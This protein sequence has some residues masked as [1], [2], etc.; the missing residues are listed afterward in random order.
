MKQVCILLFVLVAGVNLTA[1]TT[2]PPVVSVS[3]GRLRGRLSPPPGGAFFL[4]VPFAEPPVGDL[5]WR[6]PVP[7]KPWTGVREASEFGSPC[8]QIDAGWNHDTA[9]R[10]AEDCLYL[11]IWTPEWPEKSPQP[12]MVWLHGGAN[13]GG[14]ASFGYYG[15]VLA[16]KGVVIVTVNYR[17]GVLGFLA[18]PELTAES[19]HHSSGNYGLLDQIAALRWV[20]ENIAKFG[21]DP[22][23]VTIFG[24]SAGGEDVGMLMTS[25]LSEGLFQR[26]I[27]QSGTVLIG[28]RTI[29]TREQAEQSG[30]DYAAKLNAPAGEVSVFL[31]TLPALELLKASPEYG[32]NE[33]NPS[34]DNWVLPVQPAAV[35]A[36][37]QE[38]KVDLMI[39][40][41]AIEFPYEKS[42][43]ALKGEIGKLLGDEAAPRAFVLY[44]LTAVA[45]S[46]ANAAY[47]DA[48]AQWSSDWTFRCPAIQIA[49][50]HWAAGNRVYQYEFSLPAL[51]K[52]VA[53]HSADLR[54]VWGGLGADTSENDR[55]I[56]EQMQRYWTNFA[57]TGDPNGASLPRWPKYDAKQRRY[58]EF[59][60][61]GVVEKTNLRRAPCDL[62]NAP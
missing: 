17:L 55:L 35:F 38:H 42:E 44:G 10:G 19:P 4:G 23:R 33:G 53:A 25:P 41:N 39:G 40:N 29:R 24:Q 34:L 16:R 21:G 14:T 61:Q 20:H 37:G 48:R 54:F 50:Q 43:E 31:R 62:L 22:K 2:E 57:K 27:A 7:A 58:I 59:T 45:D 60:P 49:L 30:V 32:S 11:N 36:Q 26:A 47:G 52:Q 56:S 18:H 12:V 9:V 8:A 3:G 1:Q 15:T 51:G 13:M 6:E 46:P 5:R 28:G